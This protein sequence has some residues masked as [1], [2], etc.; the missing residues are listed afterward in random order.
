ML[1]ARLIV[2]I[3]VIAAAA[4]TLT[5][6]PSL[7]PRSEAPPSLDA[8]DALARQGDQVGAARMYETLA[9][10]NSGAD[11][12]EYLF[13]AT[14]AYLSAHKPDEAARVLATVEP[15]LTAQQTAERPLFDAELAL[16]RGQAQQAFNRISSVPEPRTAPEALRYWKIREDA[17]L[18]PG[19]LHD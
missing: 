3:A 17:A 11:R 19:R 1:P 8:A 6:C 5:G 10:Q 13:R 7:G 18:A 9:G 12:N 16:A 15:P 14:R 4:L 2:R